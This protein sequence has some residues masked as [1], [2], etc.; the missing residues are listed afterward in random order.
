MIYNDFLLFYLLLLIALHVTYFYYMLNFI[1]NSIIISNGIKNIHDT[2]YN[3][4]YSTTI[5]IDTIT[6]N[7]TNI[8][9]LLFNNTN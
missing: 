9:R 8:S 1:L 3:I 6:Y 4:N 2:N 7:N 5:F